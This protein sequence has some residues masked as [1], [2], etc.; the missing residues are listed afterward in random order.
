MTEKLQKTEENPKT[1]IQDEIVIIIKNGKVVRFTQHNFDYG[2]QG[3]DG[4]GI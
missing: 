3:M 4:E 1:T 2:K